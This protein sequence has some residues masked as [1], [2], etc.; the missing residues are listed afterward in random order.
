[1]RKPG[2]NTVVGTR[3]SATKSVNYADQV[4]A[5]Y[6]SWYTCVINI[7]VRSATNTPLRYEPTTW[8][9]GH[10]IKTYGMTRII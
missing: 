5:K 2:Q 6:E 7:G 8:S 3:T 9:L 10:G 4:Y 1:M